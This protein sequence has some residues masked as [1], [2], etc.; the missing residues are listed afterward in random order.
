VPGLSVEPPAPRGRA[1]SAFRTL[2]LIAAVGS[3]VSNAL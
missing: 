1:A 3:S 2:G